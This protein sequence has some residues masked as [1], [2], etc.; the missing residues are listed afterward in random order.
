MDAT[1][2]RA[3]GAWAVVVLPF[4]VLAAFLASRGELTPTVVALYWFP[5]AVLSLLGVLPAPW[6]VLDPGGRTA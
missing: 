4:V 1:R 5:A 3:L 6:S 2:Q